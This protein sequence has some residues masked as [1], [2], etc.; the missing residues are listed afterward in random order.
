MVCYFVLL[1]DNAY[2]VA[3]LVGA[4]VACGL[5]CVTLCASILLVSV[6]YAFRECWRCGVLCGICSYL[7][8]WWCASRW[9]WRAAGG[10]V[11]ADG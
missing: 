6:C 10:V 11:D 9:D 4:A 2:C 5:L 1:E 8:C 7:V 3:D